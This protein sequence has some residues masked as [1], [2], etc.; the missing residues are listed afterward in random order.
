MTESRGQRQVDNDD[1]IT[2]DVTKSY[3]KKEL[4]LQDFM[5]V[6]YIPLETN[7]EFV[8]QGFVMDIGKKFIVVRNRIN[9]GDIFV[10][11]RSG[12]ALRK[13]NHKGQMTSREYSFIY[14]ITLD[15]D[16]NEMFINDALV[17][18]IFVYDLSGKFKRSFMHRENFK[19]QPYRSIYNYDKNNLICFDEFNETSRAFVLISKK[20]GSITNETKIPYKEN[21]SL[22]IVSEKELSRTTSGSTTTVRVQSNSMIPG[23]YRTIIPF[24]GNWMLLDLSSD[25]VYTFLPDYNLRPFLVRTPSVHS[26]NLKVHVLLSFL[27]DRYFF[28]E[29]MNHE[30]DMKKIQAFPELLSSC[31]TG[32]KRLFLS[33]LCT[34]ETIQSKKK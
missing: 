17:R 20:D 6:E 9:D 19:K 11:D 8:N 13:I 34:M 29:K 31:T 27:S 21:I 2:V 28:M 24:K 10:Y 4:I 25:T 12:K 30:Y 32:R 7:D 23:R 22:R 15:E 16:N 5:D 3:P 18:K 14:W 26:M 1:I 33:I